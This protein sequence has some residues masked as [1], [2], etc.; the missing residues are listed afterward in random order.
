MKDGWRMIDR[1]KRKK[2]TW[3]ENS[4]RRFLHFFYLSVLRSSLYLCAPHLTTTA[5]ATATAILYEPK[6][7]EPAHTNT[8]A[9]IIHSENTPFAASASC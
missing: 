7:I 3:S 4:Y 2:R 9:R 8:L 5:T 1:K 6:H